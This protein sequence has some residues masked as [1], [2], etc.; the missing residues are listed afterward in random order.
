MHSNGF[1]KFVPALGDGGYV[2]MRPGQLTEARWRWI[3]RQNRARIVDAGAAIVVG[4]RVY[5]HPSR[6]DDVLLEL[7]REAAERR[8]GADDVPAPARSDSDGAA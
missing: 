4:G 5:V 2:A 3:W 1:A 7:G 6:M 8:L